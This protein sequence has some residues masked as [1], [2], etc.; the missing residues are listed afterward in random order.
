MKIFLALLLINSSLTFLSPDQDG[1]LTIKVVGIKNNEGQIIVDIFSSE[2]GFPNKT[3]HAI[4]RMKTG[5]SEGECIF[6][7]TGLI[8][9]AYAF[10]IVHDENM[11]NKLDENFLGMPKEGVA[12]S[13]NAKGFLGPPSFEDSSFSLDSILTTVTIRL[14]YL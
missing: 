6:N 3:E 10:R 1:N 4:K 11:N 2:L 13:N 7:V 5:I 8:K 14:I 12:A 9:G